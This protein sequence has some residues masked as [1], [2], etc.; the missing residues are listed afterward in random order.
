MQV[1]VVQQQSRIEVGD[2]SNL[3]QQP[4]EPLGLCK[5]AHMRRIIVEVG[6]N[7]EQVLA[8]FPLWLQCLLSRFLFSLPHVAPIVEN[9]EKC[10]VASR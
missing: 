4:V 10:V 5:I 2:L 6:R 1:H 8:D 3:P 7:L 9:H